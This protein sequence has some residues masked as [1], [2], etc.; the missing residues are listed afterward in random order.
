MTPHLYAC[1]HDLGREPPLNNRLNLQVCSERL[2]VFIISAMIW[3]AS[4]CVECM[5]QLTPTVPNRQKNEL[6]EMFLCISC[7]TNPMEQDPVIPQCCCGF[8]A[9]KGCIEEWL[10]SSPSCPQC[11]EQISLATDSAFST[12]CCCNGGRPFLTGAALLEP[13]HSLRCI[14]YTLSSRKL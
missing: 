10:T 5:E 2:V 6:Q 12:S 1:L 4:L 14:L 8:V 3:R 7:K 11:R 9:C 13:G